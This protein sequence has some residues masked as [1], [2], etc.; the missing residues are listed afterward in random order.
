[1]RDALIPVGSDE[2]GYLSL[3]I[4]SLTVYD[5]RE[6]LS[7]AVKSRRWSGGKFPIRASGPKE[8]FLL[9]PSEAHDALPIEFQAILQPSHQ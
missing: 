7:V 8:V 1:M 2:F 3:R 5:T 9:N 6:G 4:V